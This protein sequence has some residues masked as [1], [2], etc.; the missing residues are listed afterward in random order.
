MPDPSIY[1]HSVLL[2]SPSK[3]ES[4]RDEGLLE[5]FKLMEP[6]VLESM[7]QLANLDVNPPYLAASRLERVMPAAPKPSK[8]FRTEHMSAKYTIV[9]AAIARMRFTRVNSSANAPATVASLDLDIIPFVE[10]E[11]TIES[12]D[13]QLQA[14]RL[15]I[16][17][18]ISSLWTVDLAT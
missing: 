10:L 16:L 5:P 8:H 13:V 18:L 1:I 9:P 15:R 17:C 2:V 4:S 7:Q 11:A 3:S 12:L 14:A 6:N